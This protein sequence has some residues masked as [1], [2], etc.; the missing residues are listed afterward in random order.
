MKIKELLNR[1]MGSVI[2]WL[3]DNVDKFDLVAKDDLI[4]SQAALSI[5]SSAVLGGL[6]NRWHELA[7]LAN[8]SATAHCRCPEIAN[9]YKA[10]SQVWTQCALELR[11]KLAK[12]AA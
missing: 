9:G 12:K 6:I 4:A 8:E 2:E 10:Q 11:S 5:P 3:I 1:D 7:S